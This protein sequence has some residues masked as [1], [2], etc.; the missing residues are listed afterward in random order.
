MI[1]TPCATLCYLVCVQLCERA[2]EGRDGVVRGVQGSEQRG[3]HPG[4]VARA[5]GPRY[6]WSADTGDTDTGDTGGPDTGGQDTDTGDTGNT[7][8]GDTDM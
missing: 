3:Y 6:A 8:T 1:S 5:G 4:G 7:D 2:A